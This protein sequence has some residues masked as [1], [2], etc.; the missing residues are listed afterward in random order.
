MG[1]T[2][3][4]TADF[5]QKIEKTIDSSFQVLGGSYRCRLVGERR[6]TILVLRLHE[7]Q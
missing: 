1:T 3:F 5:N 6:D 4:R 2:S 7:R